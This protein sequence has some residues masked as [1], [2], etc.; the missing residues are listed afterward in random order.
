MLDAEAAAPGSS[1]PFEVPFYYDDPAGGGVVSVIAT[2]RGG[3][4]R[5]AYT[6][7]S[8]FHEL[9]DVVFV[10]YQGDVDI[11]D[12]IPMALSCAELGSTEALSGRFHMRFDASSTVRSSASLTDPL[13]GPVWGSIYRSTD[14]TITGPIDGAEPV[15]SFAFPL[16][17]VEAGITAEE[18]DLDVE[19]PGGDY[20]ILGFMDI[21]DNAATTGEGP[22]EGDPVFIPIGGFPMRCADEHITVEFALLLPPGR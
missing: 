7:A 18:F 11:P 4:F 1:R 8:P 19:L 12:E 5:I 2:G 17:D 16:V 3:V 14:V 22:D 9:E 10:P 6:V 20:Q 13:N 15:A 21:D